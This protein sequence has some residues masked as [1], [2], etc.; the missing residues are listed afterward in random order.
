ME[1]KNRQN[2]GMTLLQMGLNKDDANEVFMLIAIPD[3]AK[4]REMMTHPGLETKME[5]S[6]VIGIPVVKFWRPAGPQ[7]EKM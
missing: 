3:I 5:Q 4:A 7:S 2:A 1:E 6:G